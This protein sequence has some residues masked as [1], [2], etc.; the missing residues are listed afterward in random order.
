VNLPQ[1]FWT[2]VEG[3]P[4]ARVMQS[5]E[6]Q[7]ALLS[8]ALSTVCG[9]QTQVFRLARLE[10]QVWIGSPN[11]DATSIEMIQARI[12]YSLDNR[13]ALQ[14]YL[15]FLRIELVAKASPLVPVLGPLQE[16][17]GD[18]GLLPDAFEFIFYRSCA[19]KLLREDSKLSSHS[20]STHEQLRKRYQQLDRKKMELRRQEIASGLTDH[21][22]EP[23][24]G[25]G[26]ASDFTELALVRRQI[27]LQR[28]HL[29]LRELFRRAGNAIQTLKPCFMMSP[30]SVAQ[31]LDPDGIRFDLVVMDEAS[32]IR[33]E[34]ALGALA[35]GTQV[36]VVGDPMQLPP[37]SFFE[38]VDRDESIDEDSEEAEVQDLTGQESILDLARGPY[39]PVRQLR[40]HYRSRHESLIAF[41]NR[42]FYDN[43]LIVF[44]SPHH[45]D[46]QFGVRVVEVD[47]IY[48][49]G[50]N[51]REAEATVAAAQTFM[52]DFAKQSLG[53][54]AMNKV[55]QDLLQKLMDDLF[56]SDVEAEAYRLQWENTLEPTFV[57]NLENVQGDERD[58]IFISTVYGK[59][60]AG[61]FYQR[62]GPING[63][64]GH[65]R[66]N[67]LFTR[68]KNQVRLFT[69]MKSTDLRIEAKTRWGVKALKNYLSFAK[70]GHFE[71]GDFTAREPDSEFERWVIQMLRE[72][73][74]EVVP[75]V[76]V[77]GYFIDL[78]VRHPDRNGAFILGVECDGAMYHSARSV[79]DRDRLRQEI[80]ERLNWNIYR[81]WSTDWFRNPRVEIEKLIAR[82]EEL[83]R[84]EN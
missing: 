53:I 1:V 72:A 46:P 23:G 26:R 34:D 7:N 66:L 70:D 51:R 62:L 8:E 30:M 13:D 44:P 33:P 75:Q 25:R 9:C 43:S 84:N 36:V 52:R 82:I 39:Q 71:V 6:M 42:E 67:V 27:G 81:I 57:K 54:V 47:G 31:F 14:P 40:W 59:D 63:V 38:K 80:L 2:K 56:A 28:R 3:E 20:G 11:L 24:V 16:A 50:Q 79:R 35:R 48:E 49:S 19:E 64:H 68:A 61:N 74:Y 41:S 15:D 32:Q 55:Q 78:A 18:Y 76:G 5:L 73:G 77:A 12:N 69:S 60:A 45:D 10:C 17:A 29:A 37:T 21:Q 22:V 65:R 4:L 83:R 58:V